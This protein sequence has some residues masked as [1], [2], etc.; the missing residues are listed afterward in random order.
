MRNN[1][2]VIHTVVM[3]FLI[4]NLVSFVVVKFSAYKRKY[5]TFYACV[6]DN[7]AFVLNGKE[8]YNYKLKFEKV[9]KMSP[10]CSMVN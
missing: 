9:N 2:S 5:R 7:Q 10:Q 4:L 6:E 8:F 3:M 1:D